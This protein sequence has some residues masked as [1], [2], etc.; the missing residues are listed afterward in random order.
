MT[1]LNQASSFDM[2]MSLSEFS[3]GEVCQD[4]KIDE[5][6]YK[7]NHEKWFHTEWKRSVYQAVEALEKANPGIDLIAADPNLKTNYYNV[8]YNIMK[9]RVDRLENISNKLYEDPNILSKKIDSCLDENIDE[10]KNN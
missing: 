8:A 1:A 6:K 9:N 10:T 4:G 7:G 3:F 2:S 5:K